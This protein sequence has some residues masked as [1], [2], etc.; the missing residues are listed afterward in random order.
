MAD[1]A[2]TPQKGQLKRK[3][4]MREAVTIAAGSVIGV[5]LFTTARMSSATWD[6]SSSSPRC[7]R[8]P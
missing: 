2:V 8:L 5:G 3:F 4:G 6:R 1:I 7:S